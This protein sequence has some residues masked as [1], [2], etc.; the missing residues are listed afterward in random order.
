MLRRP[1]VCYLKQIN[2]QLGEV[3]SIN[4]VIKV[5]QCFPLYSKQRYVQS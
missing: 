1:S 3:I 2:M 4:L 5:K